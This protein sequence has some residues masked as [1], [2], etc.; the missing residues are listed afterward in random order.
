[1]EGAAGSCGCS[2]RSE[3][4]GDPG[5]L[6]RRTTKPTAANV[7]RPKGYAPLPLGCTESLSL[8]SCSGQALLHRAPARNAARVTFATGCLDCPI[9]IG[10]LVTAAHCDG[11]PE[12]NECDILDRKLQEHSE[13]R[14]RIALGQSSGARR[15][16]RLMV[17]LLEYLYRYHQV[18]L[19]Q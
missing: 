15:S 10:Q 1:M 14:D 17:E 5:D 12:K 8:R 4:D 3:E 11:V 19:S 18:R 16:G 6:L 2:A 9:P 13:K 7:R